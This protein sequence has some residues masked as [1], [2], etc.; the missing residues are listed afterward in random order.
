MAV[1]RLLSSRDDVAI[2]SR[3]EYGLTP[4]SRA[5]MR[6]R[7]A[8]VKLLLSRD[9]VAVDTRDNKDRTP[10]YHAAE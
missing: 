4:L 9:D 1:V 6:G 2:D 10:I 5:A 7:G 3:D 8:I